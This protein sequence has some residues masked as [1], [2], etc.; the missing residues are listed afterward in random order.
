MVGGNVNGCDS[1]VNLNLTI[2]QSSSSLIAVASCGPY[3][4]PN[5]QTYTESS[6]FS[7]VMPNANGCDSTIT[8]NL[9]ISPTPT[10]AFS[11]SPTLLE[12][13]MT[14]IQML[15]Q[16]VG[17]ISS[18]NWTYT[19]ANSAI[20]TSTL[21]NPLF[22]IPTNTSGNQTFQLAV[23]NAQGCTSEITSILN[24]VE[25]AALY[26]PNTFS[27]DGNAFNNVFKVVGRNIDPY[28]FELTI[29]N[30]WGE[31]IFISQDQN[32]GWDGAVGN[33]GIAPNGTY[34][35]QVVY[36]FVNSSESQTLTGHLNLI[37]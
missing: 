22:T 35:Y 36:R 16:S 32:I 6:S 24:I 31:I 17:Q 20:Q 7:Y 29:Y 1:V 34:T 2:N 3:F 26:I 19:T 27:P 33:K 15:D 10:A 21:Q 37:R 25:D 9:T 13:G 4:A 30:R 5:G 23:S 8:V 14:E 12:F 11:S 18:W 28:Q